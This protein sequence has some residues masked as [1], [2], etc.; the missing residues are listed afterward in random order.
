MS[1]KK[2]I[3]IISLCIV[4][5][6]CGLREKNEYPKEK[7]EYPQEV[8]DTFLQSCEAR[9]GGKHDTCVCLLDKVQRKY[10]LEE[11]SVLEAKMQFDKVPDDFIEF[12]G[13]AKAEC[14]MSAAL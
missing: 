6:T 3:P 7:N 2:L 13:K 4:L 10:T 9:A 14:A 5:S 8:V 1:I 11:F 12:L